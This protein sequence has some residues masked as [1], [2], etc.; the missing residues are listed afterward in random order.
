MWSVRAVEVTGEEPVTLAEIKAQCRVDHDDDDALLIRLG[1]VAREMV[2]DR[3][4]RLLRAQTVEISWDW[5]ADPFRLPRAPISDVL[6]V[7]YGDTSIP[8]FLF[9]E[10]L[11]VPLLGPA[12]GARWPV[13]DLPVIVRASA[14]YANGACPER[15]RHA[16]VMMVAAWY[17]GRENET[18]DPMTEVPEGAEALIADF[19]LTWL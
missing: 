6:S 12:V 7:T 11:S 14:G 2:E 16:I 9:R 10:R 17:R 15:L 19:R 1:K 8:D 4:G 3:T 5:F 13:T 18:A